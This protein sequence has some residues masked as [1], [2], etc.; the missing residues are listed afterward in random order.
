LFVETRAAFAA[1]PVGCAELAGLDPE[2]GTELG[3]LVAGTRPGRQSAD[4]ITVYKAMG[5]VVED[6]VAAELV[7]RRAR[8]RGAGRVV[9][10]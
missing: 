8:E 1:P 10:L 3:E 4:E 7:H 2:H 9:T 6:V 5:H